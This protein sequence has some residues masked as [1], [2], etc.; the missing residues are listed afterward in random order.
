M[1]KR[2]VSAPL[3]AAAVLGSAS[4]CVLG[5]QIPGLKNED[6]GYPALLGSTTYAN[7]KYTIVGGGNDIWGSSDN[8]HYAYIIV[9]GDFDYIVKVESLSGPDNWTKAELMAREAADWGLGP[10]PEGDDRHISNM[11]TR[12]GGQNE[13]A[14]QWRSNN[15]GSGS[16]WPN[17]IGITTPVQRPTYPN[18]WLRLE[19]MGSKFWG[20]ASTDGQSW[21]LLRGSPYD[22]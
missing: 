3:L 18:T 16:A 5:Q 20:Y 11:T 13:V 1:N 6:V 8:F 22:F 21:T 19:R 17:D 10:D 7:G 9:T 15:R 12:S 4:L 2:G 14:L